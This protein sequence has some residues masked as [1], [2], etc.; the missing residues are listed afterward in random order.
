[1]IGLV[2]TIERSP[3]HAKQGRLTIRGVKPVEIDQQAH[4]A[5]AK[6]MSHRLEAGMHDLA[7]VKR[8]G[9][10]LVL[11]LGSFAGRIRH[12]Y[13]AACASSGGASRH[14]TAAPSASA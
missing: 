5:V 13:S 1:V 8:G 10:D 6:A 7:K 9:I 3:V 2:E 11:A 4:H 12:G 14:G